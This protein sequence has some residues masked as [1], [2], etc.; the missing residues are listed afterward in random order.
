MGGFT[1]KEIEE[2]EKISRRTARKSIEE[3]NKRYRRTASSMFGDEAILAARNWEAMTRRYPPTDPKKIQSIKAV[4]ARIKSLDDQMRRLN[5]KP[6][7][8]HRSIEEYQEHFMRLWVE[9]VRLTKW[10]WPL[11]GI[12]TDQYYTPRMYVD[13]ARRVM[14]CI[15]C[16][17]ASNDWANEHVVKAPVYYTANNTGLN[18][19]WKGNVWINPPYSPIVNKFIAKLAKEV[20]AGNCKQAVVLWQTMSRGSKAWKVMESISSAKCTT[21]HKIEFVRPDGKKMALPIQNVF[22]YVGKRVK[23]FEKE[24]RKWGDVVL[25]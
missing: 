17:P 11:G 18:K 24:F 10:D 12:D 20:K 3:F 19:P 23:K 15:D 2:L 6:V 14:G 4:H 5:E 21:N 16:D 22:F 7:S 8:E 1:D 9:F 13:A 25:R